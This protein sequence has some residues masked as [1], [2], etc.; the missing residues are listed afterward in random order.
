[1]Y[2]L[3]INKSW[4]QVELDI[5]EKDSCNDS[6]QYWIYFPNHHSAWE[7]ALQEFLHY[8]PSL[9]VRL[10]LPVFSI[11]LPFC[12]RPGSKCPLSVWPSITQPN[13]LRQVLRYSNK[14]PPDGAEAASLLKH[15][16]ELWNEWTLCWSD[17]VT[18]VDSW[19]LADRVQWHREKK[20][21]IPLIALYGLTR[22]CVLGLCWVIQHP[23]KTDH[24]LK[25]RKTFYL[26][27][28]HPPFSR[29]KP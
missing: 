17:A 28:L 24:G 14:P 4:Y 21:T 16:W 6:G 8:W 13:H 20:I 11:T 2:P 29:G 9:C 26:F 18:A 15:L 12:H 25:Y 23:Q 5:R 3:T 1:M 22:S 7:E 19:L 27:N 10:S